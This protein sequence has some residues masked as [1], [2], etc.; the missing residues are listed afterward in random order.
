MFKLL[1]RNKY[2]RKL[3]HILKNIKYKKVS[4]LKDRMIISFK[5]DFEDKYIG[6][7]DWGEILT[8]YI[9]IRDINVTEIEKDL[10]FLYDKKM[11]RK[12]KILNIIK[13]SKKEN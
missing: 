13:Q 5:D 3:S 7:Y 10:E 2:K 8:K 6:Y 4:Y 11:L 1:I 9:R 12:Y